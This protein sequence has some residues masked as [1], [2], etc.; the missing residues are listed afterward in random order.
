MKG[1]IVIGYSGYR[2]IY[3]PDYY[4]A[5]KLG[6]VAEHRYVAEQKLGRHLKPGEIVHHIDR[7]RLN[8]H[9]NN[10]LVFRSRQDHTRYHNGGT[11]IEMDDGTYISTFEKPK[12]ACQ[13]CGKIFTPKTDD[14]K[15]CCKECSTL[16]SRRVARPS[17]SELKNLLLE[18]SMVQIAQIYGITDNGVRRWCIMYKLPYRLKEIK[19]MREKE[20]L[21]SEE[22]A[23]NEEMK[24]RQKESAA[25]RRKN[26]KE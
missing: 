19:K 6:F 16:A 17:K 8:N 5:T 2:Q 21:K 23:K 9:P 11:L 18:L 24:K 22:R 10:L 3:M 20:R 14:T 7:N 13:Y 15:Y 1:M 4:C 26:E 12:I 25:L